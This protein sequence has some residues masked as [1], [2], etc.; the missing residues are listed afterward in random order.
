[1]KSEKRY[2][3]RDWLY[4]KYVVEG[5]TTYEIGEI[6]GVHQQTIS[7]WLKRLDIEARRTGP[8]RCE[9]ATFLTNT[10]GYEIWSAKYRSSTEN[11]LVHR[12]LA[13]CEYGLEAIKDKDI[14]HINGIPWD[15][16]PDNIVP[17]TKE[18]HMSLH[19][20]Q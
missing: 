3:Q 8:P 12:L 13:Y 5:L 19:S 6:K 18:E 7:N 14:H 9:Y 2:Q 20:N 16:Q 1:M 11:L 4:Q 17:L 15:N 10:R